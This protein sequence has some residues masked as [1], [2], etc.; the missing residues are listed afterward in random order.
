[1]NYLN[2]AISL[3]GESERIKRLKIEYTLTD[4]KREKQ[5]IKVTLINLQQENKV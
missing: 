2:H 4:D 3:Y 5:A 1:M